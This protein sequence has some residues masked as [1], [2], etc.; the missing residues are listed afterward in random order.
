[1]D[2]ETLSYAAG[3]LDGEGC[4]STYVRGNNYKIVVSCANSNRPVIEWF[5]TM[6]G[7]SICRNATRIRKP[8]HRRMFSWCVVS[9]DAARFCSMIA[10]Y[11][12][13]K[14]E[15][16]LLLIAIQHT[17]TKGGPNSVSLEI[18]EERK[19]LNS[20]LKEKKHVTWN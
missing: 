6:F 7:G 18:I 16:A 11:L 17:M 4:F 19:R 1:M 13:E 12:K 15:Q 9:K 2:E 20:I 14:C 5:R 3:F 10:P 8:N